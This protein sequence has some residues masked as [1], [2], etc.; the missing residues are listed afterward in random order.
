MSERGQR[1]GLV[2]LQLV[3]VL[4]ERLGE[5]VVRCAVLGLAQNRVLSA[6]HIGQVT[7]KALTFAPALLSCAVVHSG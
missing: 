2:F 5:R 1:C 3:V 7:L 4:P 6:G